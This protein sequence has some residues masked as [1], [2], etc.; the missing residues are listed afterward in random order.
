[1]TSKDYFRKKKSMP[2]CANP[3]MRPEDG[4]SAKPGQEL[5]T[6]L[7]RSSRMLLGKSATLRSAAPR[8]RFDA[9]RPE[10]RYYDA[11]G[12][13]DPAEELDESF[14]KPHVAVHVNYVDGF[15]G[16]NSLVI[17]TKDAQMIADLMLG[18]EGKLLGCAS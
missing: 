7:S 6:Y 11:A 4:P 2:C 1:M 16:I 18:G 10:S 17:K 13:A 9:A 15:Q 3:P 5:N 8:R 12:V 14:P